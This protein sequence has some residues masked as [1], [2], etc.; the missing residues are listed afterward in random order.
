[1]STPRTVI[2]TPHYIPP[3]PYGRLEIARVLLDHGAKASLEND[4]AQTPLH[5]VSQGNY[6]FQDDGPGVAKL[7]LER[8]ADMHAQ[9]RMT[10][11]PY[12]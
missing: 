4:R 10:Q 5:F 1:M 2:K 11:L 3:P 7:L 6:W 12:I 8:G 9:M